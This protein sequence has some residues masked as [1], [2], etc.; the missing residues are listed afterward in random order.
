MSP[1]YLAIFYILSSTF[2]FANEENQVG[3]SI[4]L[5]DNIRIGYITEDVR[6][7]IKKKT[8]DTCFSASIIVWNTCLK[9][10]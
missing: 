1:N 9:F 8:D 3:N 6:Y 2:S 7:K 10:F 5:V 4:S